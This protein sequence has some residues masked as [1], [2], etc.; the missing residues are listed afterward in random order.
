MTLAL[1][2]PLV[3]GCTGITSVSGNETL[4][5]KSTP[6]SASVYIMDKKIGET[7][8]EIGQETLYPTAYD[9]TKQEQYG[10]VIIK[11]DGCKEYSRR[12]GYRELAKDIDATLE[13]GD[14]QDKVSIEKEAV[15]ATQSDKPAQAGN[16]GLEPIQTKSVKDRLMEL[17]QLKEEGLLSPDEYHAIRQRIL[18]SI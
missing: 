9:P 11:S 6:S 8:L 10:V 15:A 17:N 7:P 14:L 3:T 5:V 2:L 4:S 12:I 18:D 16:I 13:C 1:C